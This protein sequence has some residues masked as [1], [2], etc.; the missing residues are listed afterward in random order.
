MRA[1]VRVCVWGG[2]GVGVCV[3]R[4]VHEEW[5]EGGCVSYAWTVAG[6]CA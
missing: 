3:R 1:C 2:G 6:G 5:D 4:G